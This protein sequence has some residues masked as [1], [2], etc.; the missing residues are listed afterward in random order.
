MNPSK[1]KLQ[2][3]SQDLEFIK[4]SFNIEFKKKKLIE[5]KKQMENSLFW[6][7]QKN[8]IE[9]TRKAKKYEDQVSLI[10]RLESDIIDFYEFLEILGEEDFDLIK[11]IETLGQEISKYKIQSMFK[12]E[13]S[14]NN[15]FID[16]NPGAGGT[17]SQDWVS[18]LSNM[19]I[20]WSERS[21]YKT[22]VINKTNGDE[23]GLKSISIKIS[24]TSSSDYAFGLLKLESGIHRLVR[25]SPFDSSARRHTSFASVSVYPEVNVDVD[26]EINESELRIDSYR[27]SGAGGQH[28]NT[29][30]SAIRIT[31]IPTN[32]VVQCQNERSQHKNKAQ[33][34]KMLK[35]KL[36]QIEL[37]KA[38]E[39]KNTDY[40]SKQD[41]SWGNQKRSYV[42]HP[43]KMIKDLISNA[44][45]GNTRSFLDGYIDDFLYKQIEFLTGVKAD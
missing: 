37:D 44:E 41:I 39:K 19:Y 4:K 16:I 33:A 7:D 12:D 28:V 31:H 29:T 18:M 35:S 17:E 24:N 40:K 14:Q 21:G 30:D 1:I 3:L 11:K 27:A 10:L 9:V 25:I 8:A 38:E 5:L 2:A 6:N 22:E 45:T 42:L 23:A 13:L 32:I 20:K 34:M 26:I 36:Y 43:Y 15:C